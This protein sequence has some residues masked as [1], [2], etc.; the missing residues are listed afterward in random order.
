MKL[1]PILCVSVVA[2][3]ALLLSVDGATAFDC[4]D[5]FFKSAVVGTPP[6]AGTSVTCTTM[7]IGC[8]APSAS[9]VDVMSGVN[10][11]ALPNQAQFSYHCA[12]NQRPPP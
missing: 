7:A 1:S 8:L 4:T 9:V 12:Y 5:G 2:L 10:S 11:T 3:A 6:T